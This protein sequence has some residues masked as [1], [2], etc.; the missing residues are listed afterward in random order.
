MS[1]MDSTTMLTDRARQARS[2]F[3]IE[4]ANAIDFTPTGRDDTI[5]APGPLAAETL[6][7]LVQTATW[8][9]RFVKIH[10]IAARQCLNAARAAERNGKHELAER[11]LKDARDEHEQVRTC[12]RIVNECEARADAMAINAG[13]HSAKGRRGRSSSAGVSL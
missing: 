3:A 2:V 13:V 5:N 9:R 8:V 6:P 7:K 10:K 12:M 11:L 4:S 1:D